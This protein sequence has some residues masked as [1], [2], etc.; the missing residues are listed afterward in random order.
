MHLIASHRGRPGNDPIFTLS[1]MAS[2]R[3]AAGHAVINATLG[4]M[5]D[6][7]GKLCVLEAATRALREVAPEQVA[8][9]APIGGPPAF[10]DAV[11]REVC[12]GRADLL[13]RAVAV[14]TVGGTGAL[15]H[16]L[17]A[18]VGEG[19]AFLTS[20]Y[21]WGPYATIAAEHGRQVRT[22]SMFKGDSLDIDA[23]DRELRV[24]LASQGRAVLLLNDPCHNPTGY[25]M[26]DEDWRALGRVLEACASLG[27]ISVILDSAYAAF[28]EGSLERPVQA[29]AG[30]SNRI[31]LAFC[32]SASK[33]FLLYGQRVGAL[34]VVPPV[35]EDMAEIEGAMLF[36]CRGTW[37]NGNH[38]GMV[39]ATRLLTDPVLRPEVDGQRA[40]VRALL[41]ERVSRWNAVARSLGLVYP[42]YDGGFFVTVTSKDP[43]RHA[44]ALREQ[45]C[46]V[47]PVAGALRV[48]LC[49]VAA[50]DVERLARAMAEVLAT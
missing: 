34:V 36:A 1:K 49:S 39:A 8:A 40:R 30:L 26:S 11:K 38:A 23:L 50:R 10:L 5:I 21:Y 20:S 13:A 15:R 43:P 19:E 18:F 41:D 29:L 3:K 7:E 17:T 33:T 37:S 28:S 35:A 42:R 22:F 14:A 48:A 12:C 44:A 24:L 16:A 2:D 9:Y 46:F 31:L 32:W 4:A 6:D 45:D 27:P 25:S 47:V